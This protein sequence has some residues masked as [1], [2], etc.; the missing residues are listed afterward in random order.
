LDAAKN[1]AGCGNVPATRVVVRTVT[2][3]KTPRDG[4]FGYDGKALYGI[5]TGT[6]GTC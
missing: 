5:V 3:D 1:N 6:D 2:L 4:G